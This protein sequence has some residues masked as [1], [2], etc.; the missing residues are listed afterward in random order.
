M[1]KHRV[2]V[3]AGDQWHSG[4]IV[5]K[6]LAA[7]GD[8][9]FDFEFA[10]PDADLPAEHLNHFDAV[11]LAKA[12]H[13]GESDRGPW[14]TPAAESA[15]RTFVRSGHGLF[16]IHGGNS[17]GSVPAIR[18][19]AGGAFLRHP[20]QCPVTLEPVST[21]AL[22]AGVNAFTERDEH[23]MMTVDAADAEIFLRSQ[24]QHGV[25]PAGWTRTEGAG[26]VCV[27]TP[28]HNE[29]VWLNP[30]FQKLLR[31]GLAWLATLN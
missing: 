1:V 7:L 5:G 28:G 30:E 3:L 24:S 14:V 19:L 17:Y 23:Y 16:F 15:L 27:L 10:A 4:R 31:N 22:A 25:Q 26:R 2:L 29:G 12:N 21:H 18:G 11:V 13:R 9:R 6:S 20:D 8:D